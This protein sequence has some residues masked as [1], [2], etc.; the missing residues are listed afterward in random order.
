[1]LIMIFY[2]VDHRHLWDTCT[3]VIPL[4]LYNKV[5]HW[6]SDTPRFRMFYV[7]RFPIYH[8]VLNLVHLVGYFLSKST[9]SQH[10]PFGSLVIIPILKTPVETHALPGVPPSI[11]TYKGIDKRMIKL[12]ILCINNTHV[13]II[14]YLNEHY[15]FLYVYFF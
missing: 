5:P 9:N 13:S 14:S 8:H 2:N 15:V 10:L 12:S 1:M 7:Y 4:Y 6:R 11:A 3:W